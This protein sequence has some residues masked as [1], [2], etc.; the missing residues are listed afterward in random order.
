MPAGRARNNAKHLHATVNGL[1]AAMNGLL[2]TLGSAGPKLPP[3][4]RHPVV[5][6]PSKAK[7]KR[8]PG[9]GNPKLKSA[10]K[11]VWANYMPKQRAARIAAMKAGHARRRRAA[12]RA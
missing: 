11:S 5:P 2:A 4:L 9:K 3:E 7:G 10:F 6:M 1:V 12:K 8:G